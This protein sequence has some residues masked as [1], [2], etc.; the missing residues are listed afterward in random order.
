MCIDDV[1]LNSSL[2]NTLLTYPSVEVIFNC[3][4]RGSGIL[5]WVSDHY[6]GY[7]HPLQIVSHANAPD[8]EVSERDNNTIA[9]RL[10]VTS[11][12]NGEII[13]ISQLR[14]MSEEKYLRSSV[15]CCNLA[16]GVNRTITFLTSGMLKY[17]IVHAVWYRYYV[18]LR[19]WLTSCPFPYLERSHQSCMCV[20]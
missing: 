11:D 19:N 3:T 10:N 5:V 13:I 2:N 7:N 8:T 16:L 12:E 14:L 20:L 15:A 6:I 9:S 17:M 4:T 18:G 1:I